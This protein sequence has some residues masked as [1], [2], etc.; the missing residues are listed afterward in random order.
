MRRTHIILG[1]AI[2][3]LTQGA[4]ANKNDVD[5]LVS[6][7]FPLTPSQIKEIKSDVSERQKAA[8]TVPAMSGT[9]GVSRVLMTSLNPT[10]H[11]TPPNVRLGVGVVT[12]LIFTD[13]NGNVLPISSY[14]IGNSGD[15]KVDWDKKN[16]VLMM[17]AI[18]PYSQTNMAVMLNGLSIPVTITLLSTQSQW[19]YLDYIR[20][21]D[22][23]GH[24]DSELTQLDGGV[25]VDLL[26]GIVPDQ[27]KKLTVSD[28]ALSAWHYQG[29]YLLITEGVLVSPSWTHHAEDNTTTHINAYEINPTSVVL[30]S[31]S[32][33]L[34]KVMIGGDDV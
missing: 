29:H 16:N 30:V 27:A 31:T 34:K 4:F 1:I 6:S 13:A 26:H 32:S 12:S 7:M 23:N 19:D 9:Q 15:F 14:V 25:L 11:I 20:V 28:S 8:S 18:K 24:S 2:G 3:F 17:Q 10:K 5:Q 21:I 33:G 22:S